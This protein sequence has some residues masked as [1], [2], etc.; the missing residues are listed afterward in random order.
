MCL[1]LA[2]LVI[3]MAVGLFIYQREPGGILSGDEVSRAERLHAAL[4]RADDWA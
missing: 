3:P 2:A 4:L 1:F